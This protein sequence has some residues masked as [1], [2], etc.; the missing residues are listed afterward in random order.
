MK[1][2]GNKL[3]RILHYNI[4]KPIENNLYGSSNYVDGLY[5]I[6]IGELKNELYWDLFNE[7][8]NKLY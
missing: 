2:I 8:N 3:N 1:E 4:E 6:L 5:S 7:L